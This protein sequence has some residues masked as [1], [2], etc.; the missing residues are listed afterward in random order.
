MAVLTLT[1]VLSCAVA[2]MVTDGGLGSDAGAVY[3]AGAPLGVFD[4]LNEP[5]DEPTHVTLQ[6][7]PP[8]PVSLVRVAEMGVCALKCLQGRRYRAEFDRDIG[9]RRRRSRCN[10]YRRQ[11]CL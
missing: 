5:Q 8:F 2:V 3:V 9:R 1:L 10:R 4:E 11:R 7:T 6:S